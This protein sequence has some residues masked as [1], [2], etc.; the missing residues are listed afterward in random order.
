VNQPPAPTTGA[1]RRGPSP[2]E[3]DAVYGTAR[4]PDLLGTPGLLGTL[5]ALGLL[6]ACALPPG[7]G[8][9]AGPPDERS[10]DRAADAAA[11]A[12]ARTV[13]T[14]GA[15]AA[16][17]ST[18]IAP[19]DFVHLPD[20]PLAPVEGPP[21]APCGPGGLLTEGTMLEIRTAWCDPA[22][23]VA[24]L[25]VDIPAGTRVDLTLA[26][27]A[28]VADGGEAHFALFVGDEPVWEHM[29]TLP[30]PANFLAPRVVVSAAHAA[31][32]PVV[33]HV[34]NHGSNTYSLIGLRLSSP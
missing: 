6:S 28:L 11:A 17:W 25:P 31:S 30:A 33:L 34:H 27:S 14:D 18:T 22:D 8:P 13:A 3:G 7:G 1:A 24:P 16:P 4:T 23:L 32:T 21:I 20:G 10:T 12:D 15:V 26:H 9:G 5:G 2:V 19:T 29:T